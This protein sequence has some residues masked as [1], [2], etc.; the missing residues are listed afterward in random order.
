M[1]LNS[2]LQKTGKREKCEILS[3][4]KHYLRRLSMLLV[5]VNTNDFGFRFGVG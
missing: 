4:A 3:V 5:C 1:L 2:Y